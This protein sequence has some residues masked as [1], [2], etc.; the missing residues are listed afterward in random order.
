[1]ESQGYKKFKFFKIIKYYLKRKA[2]RTILVN[3]V[4]KLEE[5]LCIMHNKIIYP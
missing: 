3:K 4:S 5:L 2:I 1:M